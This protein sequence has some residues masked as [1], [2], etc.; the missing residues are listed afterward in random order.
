MPMALDC[1]FF[2]SERKLC[3]NCE[4]AQLRFHSRRQRAE[5]V[6][7]YCANAKGWQD[8]TVAAQLC[9]EYEQEETN[10]TEH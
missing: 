4:M 6:R 9:R 3:L 8:C 2:R 7:R 5:Y 1:P 10:G